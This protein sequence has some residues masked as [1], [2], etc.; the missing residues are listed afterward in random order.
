MLMYASDYIRARRLRR[1]YQLQMA[2][3]FEHFDVLLTPAAKGAAPR[4]IETTGDPVMNG[5]WT[6]TNFPTMTVPHALTEEGLPIG[7]QLTGPPMKEGMLLEIAKSI[8]AVAQ[9]IRRQA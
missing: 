5:P 6:L 7:V 4:G 8:E 3:L 9:F 1:K 2:K